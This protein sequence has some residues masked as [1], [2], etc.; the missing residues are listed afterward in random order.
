M[1]DMCAPHDQHSRLTRATSVRSS[2]EAN[3]FGEAPLIALTDRGD[4]G[5]SDAKGAFRVHMG[6]VR[7]RFVADAGS[8]LA[9]RG[10]A[11][12]DNA[13]LTAVVRIACHGGPAQ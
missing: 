9:L 5:A 7:A 4:V 1:N 8:V 2:N 10:R 12:A 3:S 11:A 13:A 6:S